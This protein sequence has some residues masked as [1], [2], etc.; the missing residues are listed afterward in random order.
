MWVCGNPG[1][2]LPDAAIQAI[3]QA[4]EAGKIQGVRTSGLY[5]SESLRFALQY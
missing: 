1:C 2:N 3:A 4:Q 5:R